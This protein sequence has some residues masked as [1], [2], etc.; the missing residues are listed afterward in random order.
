MALSGRVYGMVD[1]TDT[2]RHVDHVVTVGHAMKELDLTAA[3]G[4]HYFVTPYSVSVFQS[5]EPES[6][7]LLASPDLEMQVIAPTTFFARVQLDQTACL[8][9]RIR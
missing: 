6:S 2:L 7:L 4:G 8:F 9:D 5:P 3:Q 1:S